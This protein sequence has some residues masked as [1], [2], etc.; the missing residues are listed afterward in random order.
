VPSSEP[1]SAA[2]VGAVG[3]AAAAVGVADV[4][5]VAAADAVATSS[6]RLY[7]GRAINLRRRKC[8]RDCGVPVAVV[9]TAI[10]AIAMLLCQVL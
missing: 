1:A 6:L 4:A 8:G 5:A 10:A 7:S 9:T 3:A 2:A